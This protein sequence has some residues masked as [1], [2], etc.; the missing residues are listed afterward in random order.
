MTDYAAALTYYVMMSLFPALLVGISLLGLLGDQSLVTDAVVVRARPRRAGRGRQRAARVAVSDGQGRGR[1][2]ELRA[3]PRHRGR[4]LRRVGGVR[5]RRAARST[6]STAPRSR[7]ASSGTSC[8]DI[9]W[10]VVVILLALVVAVLGLPRRRARARPLRDHRARRHG[11]HDLALR[12]LVRRARGDAAHLR[13]HVLVRAGHQAAAPALDH[14]RRG[15]GRADLAPRVGAGSSSTSRTSASTARRTARSPARSSC[16]C[17]C[18]CRASRSSSERSSTPS[19]SASAGRRGAAR[20]RRARRRRTGRRPG[21]RARTGVTSR[22]VT[23]AT[24]SRR[25]ALRTRA[26][27]A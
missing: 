11:G 21:R 2:G 5:R 18:T 9:G 12:A 10:T 14:P 27:G 4:D 3:R 17:G 26:F 7:A 25:K 20:R 22:T 15:R 24:C 23:A 6:P 13:D 1:R 8:S 16:C 19:A